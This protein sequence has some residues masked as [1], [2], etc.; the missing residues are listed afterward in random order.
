M[1]VAEYMRSIGRPAPEGRKRARKAP[2]RE[3]QHTFG[4]LWALEGL[5]PPVEEWRFLQ[6]IDGPGAP[7][8]ALDYGWPALRFAVEVDGGIWMR[9]GGAHSHP[10]DILRNMDKAN[11]ATVRGVRIYRVT[12]DQVRSGVAVALVREAMRAL[13][14][15]E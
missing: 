1:S 6:D 14:L 9:G 10:R 4:K 8:S 11:A 3:V 7:A 5:P 12:T 15:L 2:S 13:K